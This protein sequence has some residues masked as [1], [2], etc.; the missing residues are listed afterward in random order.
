LIER[1][2]RTIL[3]L[4]ATLRV[5][6]VLR[7]LARTLYILLY[8]RRLDVVDDEAELRRF[9]RG[10]WKAGSIPPV[11]ISQD[12]NPSQDV[13]YNRNWGMAPPV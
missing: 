3:K 11:Y 5:L 13:L 4:R 2:L 8:L 12:Y 7:V 6:G 9:Q 10:G 1:G